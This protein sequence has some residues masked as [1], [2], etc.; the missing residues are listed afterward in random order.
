MTGT[1]FADQVSYYGIGD[2]VPTVADLPAAILAM[3][4]QPRATLQGQAAQACHR[5]NS[6][7]VSAYA[8]WLGFVS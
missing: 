1:G 2:V 8:Y 7:A 6:D 5:F 4:R 3:A